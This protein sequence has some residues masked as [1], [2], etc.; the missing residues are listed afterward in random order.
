MRK[1]SDEFLVQNAGEFVYIRYGIL[2]QV[3]NVGLNVVEAVNVGSDA[4]TERKI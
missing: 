4:Y 1:S 2:H 3:I